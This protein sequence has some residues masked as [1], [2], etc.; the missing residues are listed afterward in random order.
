MK[1]RGE[2][3]GVSKDENKETDGSLLSDSGQTPP[4]RKEN[5]KWQKP[6]LTRKALMKCCLV[7]WI[8]SSAAPQ[9]SELEQEETVGNLIPKQG[10]VDLGNHAQY[11]DE[12]ADAENENGKQKETDIQMHV[13]VNLEDERSNH[14]V[15]LDIGCI[16][17]EFPSQKEIEQYV[18]NGHIPLP[19]TFPKDTCNQVFPESILKFQSTNG[20]LHVRDW[21]VWSQQKQALYCFPCRLF[22][23]KT[24]KTS[25]SASKSALVSA[26][27][28]DSNGKW[29]KLSYRIPKHEKGNS[30][31]ECYLAWRELERR[32]LSETGV[33]IIL[34][35]SMKTEAV[36]WYNLLKHIIDVVLFLGERGLAF[37]GSSH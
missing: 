1:D 16:T 27:G 9:G 28:W 23:H 25:T 10:A 6:R 37:T 18:M 8:L 14:N 26:E 20:E 36:K 2:K 12:G 22:W 31:R 24:V 13:E 4:G 34:E 5:V 30:H 21:L 32:L 3:E 15:G 17:T 29:R 35:A 19:K 7:K 33:D 11:F